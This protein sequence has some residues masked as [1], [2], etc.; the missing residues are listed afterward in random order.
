MV[1]DWILP[2][3][4]LGMA[5][6]LQGSSARGQSSSNPVPVGV[7]AATTVDNPD[8]FDPSPPSDVKI[9]LLGIARAGKAWDLIKEV[10]ASNKPPKAGFEYLLA[11]IKFEY[12]AREG[13]PRDKVYELK[14]DE[15]TVASAEGKWYE[16]PS[17]VLPKS[18]LRGKLKSGEFCEG[19]VAFVVPQ[20]DK[21]P[22]LFF[23]RGSI[24]FQLY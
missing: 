5:I 11:R 12:Y 15:F 16:T 23:S 8:I 7:T 1:F 2:C 4:T 14:E 6:F 22:R 21:M 13:T 19:W 10:S 24:W 3:L 17:I 9:T 20:D 18:P